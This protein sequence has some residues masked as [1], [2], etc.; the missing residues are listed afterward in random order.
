MT[1]TLVYQ[2]SKKKEQ[3][4]QREKCDKK[5]HWCCRRQKVNI[6]QIQYMSIEN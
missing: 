5:M 1:Q 4:V 3:I 6:V 2:F